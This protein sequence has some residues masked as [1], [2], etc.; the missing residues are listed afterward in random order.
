[1]VHSLDN[2]VGDIVEALAKNDLIKDTIVMFF[3]DNGGPSAFLH[4]TT[5]SNY[6]LRSVRKLTLILRNE[7]SNFPQF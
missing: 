2:S 4:A 6:P 3:S 5:A 7:F 1:M